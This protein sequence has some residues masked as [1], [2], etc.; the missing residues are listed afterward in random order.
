MHPLGAVRQFKL[1][2]PHRLL[3]T[4]IYLRHYLPMPLFG[5]LF[6]MDAANVCRNI[7]VPL[8]RLEQVLPAPVRSRTLGSRK[9]TP[10][11]AG[12][13]RRVH[14]L[15][16]VLKAFPEIAGILVFHALP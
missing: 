6:E 4:L 10:D 13:R 14:T 3:L 8:P 16:E 9:V 12:L 5:V 1:D 2:L 7:H 11:D 15:K